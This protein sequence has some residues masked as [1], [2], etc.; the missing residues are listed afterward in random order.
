LHRYVSHS[1]GKNEISERGGDMFPVKVAPLT[2]ALADVLENIF[3]P[4]E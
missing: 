2:I 4:D 1:K 3:P